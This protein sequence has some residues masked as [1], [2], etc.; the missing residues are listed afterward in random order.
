MIETA[1]TNS[2]NGSAYSAEQ[3]EIAEDSLFLGALFQRKSQMVKS[4][5]NKSTFLTEEEYFMLD[6]R[7][8]I[9]KRGNS[10]SF[11][12][13]SDEEEHGKHV[14]VDLAGSDEYKD[15]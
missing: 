1:L 3:V 4:L 15:A 7:E 5:R 14:T 8:G 10:G 12:P 6:I 11:V 9:V 13:P 2:Q